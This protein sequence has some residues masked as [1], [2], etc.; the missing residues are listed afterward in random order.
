MS[1]IN[2][3]IYSDVITRYETTSSIGN[4]YFISSKWQSSQYRYEND[5]LIG[6]FTFICNPKSDDI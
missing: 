6:N 3:K 5:D 4:L 2:L 1:K